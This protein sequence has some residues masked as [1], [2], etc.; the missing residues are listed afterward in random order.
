[1][2]AQTENIQNT[3]KWRVKIDEEQGMQCLEHP[4]KVIICY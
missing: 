3:E 2:V 1:M 4:Q